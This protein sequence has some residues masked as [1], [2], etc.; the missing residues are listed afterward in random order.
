MS[1]VFPQPVTTTLIFVL[2]LALASSVDA[3]TLV[4]AA[5]LA[6]VLPLLTQGFWPSPPRLRRPLVAARL[7]GRVLIDIITAN[8]VVARQV[9]GPVRKLRPAFFE[10][11]VALDDPFVATLLG[12]I[13]SLTPGTVTI[14]IE[15]VDGKPVR[16]FVH[17][18]DVPDEA[19]TVAEIKARYE[20]PL[21][22]MFG[23]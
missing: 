2:W 1:R 3:G 4:L 13:I 21:K 14:N 9:L 23:C 11:P 19:A 10:V 15:L 8:W 22:E 6:V 7:A 17:G 18:L 12:G 20:A 5:V 16:L